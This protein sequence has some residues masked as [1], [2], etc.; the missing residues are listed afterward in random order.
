MG[1]VYQTRLGTT[2][3][4]PDNGSRHEMT[5]CSSSYGVR[6]GGASGSRDQLNPF[7]SFDGMEPA[8]TSR[9]F[10]DWAAD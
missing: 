1:P 6:Y 4:L 5:T 8:Q 7:E 9:R 2:G 10:N 3:V